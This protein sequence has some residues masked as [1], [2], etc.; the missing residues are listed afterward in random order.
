MFYKELLKSPLFIL[1]LLLACLCIN[2]FSDDIDY[3]S[4]EN[5]LKFADNLYQQG[6]YIRSAKEYERYMI[7]CPDDS[8]KALYKIGLCYRHT[9]NIDKAISIFQKIINEYP[10]SELKFSA[11]FQ[12]GYTYFI[13]GQYKNSQS[14]IYDLSKRE[15]TINQRKKL[16]ILSALNHLKQREWRLANELIRNSPDQ[17]SEDQ[18]IDRIL[19][20]LKKISFDGVNRKH[21]SRFWA[22]FMS[23]I[24]PGMGKI[25]CQQYG[26]G[27]FSFITVSSTGFLAYNGF[28]ENGLK[29]VKG[30]I[31][32]SLFS[33]FYAGNIYGSGIS[34]LAYNDYVESEII[35]RLPV[36]P[37]D[38]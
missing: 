18:N 2:A 27:F 29:S 37:D 25:Y 6:D 15:L 24:V 34:A 1:F 23:A 31:F 13:S 19:S 28:K 4:P 20:D 3:Y 21:K 16:D 9:N 33:I 8:D 35:M 14:H 32:G 36:L 30:W 26:N 5:I 10:N 17:L 7:S 22:S 12:I 11:N 38:W